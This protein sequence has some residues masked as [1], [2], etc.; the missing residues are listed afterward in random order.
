MV[1]KSDFQL[2]IPENLIAQFP[3]SERGDSRLMVL[4]GASG[5]LDHTSFSALPDLLKSG[6]RLVFNNTRVIPAR[7]FGTKAS[8]GKVEILLERITGCDTALVKIRASKS[9]RTG[10][11]IYPNTTENTTDV[12]AEKGS[13]E[14]TGRQGEFFELQTVATDR[15]IDDAVGNSSAM[16][17]LFEKHGQMPLPPYIDRVP[18]SNDADRYQTIYAQ[19]EGAV[20]APTAGLHF[21]DNLLKTLKSAGIDASFVTLHVGAGTFQPVRVE[22]L[23]QHEM[24]AERYRIDSQAAAEINSTKAAGGR[25]IAVGTTSVRTLESAAARLLQQG[26]AVT[27]LIACDDETRLFIKPGDRFRLID[28]MITNFHLPESTLIMLV[29]ALAG[30]ENT[31]S[32]YREAVQKKYRF[33]SYG[34]AMLVWP[35]PTAQADR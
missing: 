23:S 3:P 15:D 13:L 14:V 16:L 5:A 11:L 2:D 17:D 4:N 20:A 28:A 31:L 9:P 29:S 34:D 24:H 6:D 19:H 21:T 12:S 7:L 26:R 10:Q 8:G 1:R 32:A 25:I 33:Y 30:T 18:E 22:D 35:S 27:E